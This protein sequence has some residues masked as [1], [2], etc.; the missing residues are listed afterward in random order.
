LLV[1]ANVIAVLE[2]ENFSY[3]KGKEKSFIKL[4]SAICQLEC[5]FSP[6]QAL[7]NWWLYRTYLWALFV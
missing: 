2:L 1:S 7:C 6:I 4:E 5:E 3:Q